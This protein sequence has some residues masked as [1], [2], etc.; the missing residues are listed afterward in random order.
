MRS[1]GLLLLL[2]A[3]GK[4]KGI[5]EAEFIPDYADLYCENWLDCQDLAEL[6]FDGLATK[7]VCLALTG[8]EIEVYGVGCE[9]YDGENAELCLK[10]MA[11]LEC[12]AEGKEI[13]SNL[14]A[15]CQTV[16]DKCVGAPAE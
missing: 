10:D 15:S 7:E 14:P 13:G 12:P 8:P 1:I 3:C 4:D 9:R 11:S 2:A 16:F 5:P 6:Q